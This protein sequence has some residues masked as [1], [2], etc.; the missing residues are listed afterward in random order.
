MRERAGERAIFLSR[1]SGARCDVPAGG[2]PGV[3][4]TNGARV[5][6]EGQKVLLGIGL[7]GPRDRRRPRAHRLLYLSH[8][9]VRYSEG[10]KRKT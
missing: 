8:N 6:R 9:S 4:A 5:R 3:T 10:E 7:H 2:T 1:L